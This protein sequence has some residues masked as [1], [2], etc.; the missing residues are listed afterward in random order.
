MKV[1]F[2]DLFNQYL[3]NKKNY[4]DAIYSVIQEGA[5]IGGKFASKFEREY[6]KHYGIKNCIGVGNGTD[7]IYIVL[8]IIIIRF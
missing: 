5:F 7:A 6:E 4:D 8:K 2:N 1:Q 3:L